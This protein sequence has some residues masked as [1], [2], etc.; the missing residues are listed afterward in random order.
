MIVTRVSL[1]IPGLILHLRIIK[2]TN[3]GRMGVLRPPGG[4]DQMIV[5]TLI[6]TVTSKIGM[7]KGGE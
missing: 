1:R 7:R 4:P 5:I 3:V 2:S 6:V